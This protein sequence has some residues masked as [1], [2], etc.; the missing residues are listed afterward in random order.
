MKHST[1]STT[2]GA[3]RPLLITFVFLPAVWIVASL[4]GF[5][6][7]GESTSPPPG[8]VDAFSPAYVT[9]ATDD[10][11]FTP[12]DT[13]VIP[14][15]FRPL[16][17]GKGRFKIAGAGMK[18]NTRYYVAGNPL[19]TFDSDRS[20]VRFIVMPVQF[21]QDQWQ[22]ETVR[23]VLLDDTEYFFSTASVDADSI[24]I[25]DNERLSAIESREVLETTPTRLGYYSSIPS[26]MQILKF[27]LR[28]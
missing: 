6:S 18:G 12:G 22:E 1:S 16:V 25:G 15:R 21:R 9:L 5:T 11:T 7:G 14:A 27:R 4:C 17:T 13:V 20:P 2:A 23:A 19:D 28:P 24:R 10:S 3:C 8:R 26:G